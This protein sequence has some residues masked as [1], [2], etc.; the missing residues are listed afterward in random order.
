MFRQYY[1]Q[2]KLREFTNLS[3]SK[4]KTLDQ[5]SYII[6]GSIALTAIQLLFCTYLII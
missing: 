6:K 2:N 1:I 4:H 5:Y 3:K